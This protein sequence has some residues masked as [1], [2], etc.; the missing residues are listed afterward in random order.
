MTE[1]DEN[2]DATTSDVVKSEEKG[3]VEESKNQEETPEA[4]EKHVSHIRND[5]HSPSVRWGVL[6][7]LLATF[8]LLVFA[9]FGSGVTAES[10][11]MKRQRF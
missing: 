6:L 8:I 2:A 11:S 4:T 7:F 3:D 5:V 9:D 1:N 10:R